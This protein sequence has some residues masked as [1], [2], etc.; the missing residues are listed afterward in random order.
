MS[1]DA[2]GGGAGLP[3]LDERGGGGP[4]FLRRP[5]VLVALALLVAGAGA[6][7]WWARG[8]AGRG[9][10]LAAEAGREAPL[11]EVPAAADRAV[12]LEFPRW[13]GGG[14]VAEDRRLGGGGQPGDDLLALMGALCDG[15]RTGR[16][17]SALPRGTRALAA[18][19][20]PAR[21]VA[22]VDFSR[23]L[24]LGH[25]GGSAAEAATVGSIMRTVAANFPQVTSCTILVEGTQ[26]ATLA[27]HLDLSRPL[28]PRRWR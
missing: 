15:P 24:S 10:D 28:S 2:P 20:D 27:G 17:T 5:L 19:L 21:G 22:V 7:A 1:P 18:F 6:F 3:P 16:A 13:D 23:E 9:D 11:P 14:W 8:Q 4:V 12:V 25:P 26:P